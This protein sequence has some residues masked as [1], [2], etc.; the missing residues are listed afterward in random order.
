MTKHPDYVIGFPGTLQELAQSIG[1]MTYNKCADALDEQA[2]DYR[3]QAEGDRKRG[4]T[5]LASTLEETAKHLDAA[6][7]AMLKAWKICE[8][9]METDE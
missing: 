6:R 5:Q 4:N 7:D 8:P 9:R 3:R 1:R 2:K